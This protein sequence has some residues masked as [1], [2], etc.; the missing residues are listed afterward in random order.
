MSVMLQ[1][2][3][4]SSELQLSQPC[5]QRGVSTHLH[6]GGETLVLLLPRFDELQSKGLVTAESA[7]CLLDLLLLSTTELENNKPEDL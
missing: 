4:L 7:H 1:T 5:S 2:Q 6:E 3:S